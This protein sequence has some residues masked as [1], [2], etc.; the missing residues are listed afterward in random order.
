MGT[1]TTV[2]TVAPTNTLVGLTVS[3]ETATAMNDFWW[4]A[5]HDQG[6]LDGW[7]DRREME[8]A[9]LRAIENPEL[10]EVQLK[11][12]MQIKESFLND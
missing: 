4:Q 12:L 2:T 5:G 7:N 8:E 10:N 11:L 1:T 3:V 9:I 6:Y